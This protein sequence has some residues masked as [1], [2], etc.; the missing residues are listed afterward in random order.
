VINDPARTLLSNGSL[1]ATVLPGFGML[2]ASLKHDGVELLRR[3]DDLASAAAKGNTAGIPFLYPWANRLDGLHYRAAGRDVVLDPN[4]PLLHFD[5]NGLPIHGVPWA[6]L[7]WRVLKA[8]KS[9]IIAE[10]D[11]SGDLLSIFPFPH[12]VEM[13]IALAGDLAIAT[14]VFAKESPVPV[15]FGF[16]PYCGLTAIPRRDWR[17]RLPAMQRVVLDARGIPTGARE[18]FAPRDDTLGESVYDDGFALNTTTATLV[19]LGNGRSI[20]VEFS[21][22]YGFAQVYAPKNQDLVALEP[23]TAPTNAL[24]SGNGLTIVRPGERYTAEFRVKIS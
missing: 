22:G 23:M 9:S 8:A 11:W 16:H 14:T 12:R 7:A 4:S 2:V 1:E 5:G 13:Q 15:S 20:A 6:Q 21:K 19:L 17:L 24:V 3:I 18:E 10:L